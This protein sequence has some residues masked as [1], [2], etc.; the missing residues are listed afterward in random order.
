MEVLAH[1]QRE[2]KRNINWWQLIGTLTPIV[3]PIVVFLFNVAST[4][5]AQAIEIQNVKSQQE[6]NQIDVQKE[7]DK[8]G[9]KLDKIIETQADQRILIENKQNR[10]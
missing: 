2:M 1:N 9:Y 7:F 6:K 4:Q 5:K 3:I 10:K 8:V